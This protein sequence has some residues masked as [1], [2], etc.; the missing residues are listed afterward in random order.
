MKTKEEAL[1]RIQ[2]LEQKA[3]ERIGTLQQRVVDLEEVK[4]FLEQ[5]FKDS[6]DDQL[7]I[8]KDNK[9]LTE[10]LDQFRDKAASYD[11]IRQALSLP[12]NTP[13]I[14]EEALVQKLLVRLGGGQQTDI[15]LK[16]IK[17]KI[18]VHPP[19]INKVEVK[20][21][22]IR[23]KILLLYSKGMFKGKVRPKTISD[24]CHQRWGVFEAAAY[25][26]LSEMASEG[27][28]VRGKET[29]G[30]LNYWLAEGVEIVGE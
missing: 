11:I 14:D 10:K 5:K 17:S 24:E 23:G 6:V 15:T 30:G 18:T 7:R 22:T 1:E 29:A 16:E 28:L 19:E 9:D 25:K 27:I 3:T 4:K 2:E 13:I 20:T 12:S 8:E 26:A 21:D